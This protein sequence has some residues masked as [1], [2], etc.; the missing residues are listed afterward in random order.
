MKSVKYSFN[1]TNLV[2]LGNKKIYKYP[3]KTKLLSVA[4][5][6]VNGRH[7]KNKKKLYFRT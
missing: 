6:V 2:D 1:E 7:P 3:F 5:M 4:K